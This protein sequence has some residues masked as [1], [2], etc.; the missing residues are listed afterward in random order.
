MS[1]ADNSDDS[2]S[3]NHVLLQMTMAIPLSIT[4][5][6]SIPVALSPIVRGESGPCSIFFI[7]KGPR[8][9]RF[10]EAYQL[11][12]I[13]QLSQVWGSRETAAVNLEVVFQPE[14]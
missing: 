5:Y 13:S 11:H 10:V 1:A 8:H 2:S 14:N 7:R 12:I 6:D 3:S 4:E 9:L